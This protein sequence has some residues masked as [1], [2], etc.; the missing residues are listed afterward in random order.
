MSAAEGPVHVDAVGHNWH[1][2]E[3]VAKAPCAVVILGH[4][5]HGVAARVGRV[6]PGA[7]VVHGPVHELQMAVGADGV[8]VKEIRQR[9]LAD[10]QLHAALGH[11]SGRSERPGRLLRGLGSQSDDLMNLIAR[12]VWRRAKV[13]VAHHVQI[14]EPGQ[15]ERLAQPAPARALEIENQVRVVTDRARG[16]QRRVERAD[17]RRLVFG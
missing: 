15:S 3:A 13:W 12:N 2:E 14:C 11:A 9:H 6:V 10:P 1:G 4:A 8:D 16:P 5:A 17:H 7:V